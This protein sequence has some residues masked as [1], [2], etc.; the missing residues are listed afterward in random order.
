VFQEDQLVLRAHLHGWQLLGHDNAVAEDC[1]DQWDGRW[2]VPPAH[3]HASNALMVGT[4]LDIQICQRV[5]DN[6]IFSDRPRVTLPMTVCRDRASSGDL[7]V[8]S[9]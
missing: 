4:E 8:V 5:D 6:W 3:V 7:P 9:A 2:L 1:P